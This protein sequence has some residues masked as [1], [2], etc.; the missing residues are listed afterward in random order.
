[1]TQTDR[2][3]T[4]AWVL[5]PDL[6]SDPERRAA[7]PALEEAVSLAHALPEL[8]VAGSGVVRLNQPHPGMLFGKGKV[9]ELRALF[10][11]K[12]DGERATVDGLS[13]ADLE[14]VFGEVGAS[15]AP[16]EAAIRSRPAGARR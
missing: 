4:R 16:T 2:P 6:K 1:M 3:D 5:H 9:E 11:A 14:A 10:E 7:G 12:V 8:E 13:R 15:N